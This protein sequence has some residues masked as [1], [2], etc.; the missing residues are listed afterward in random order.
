RANVSPGTSVEV[1]QKQDQRTGRLTLG[2]VGR[3]LTSSGFHP[4]GI[5]VM[6]AGG[7]VGRVQ[8]IAGIDGAEPTPGNAGLN[9]AA[10]YSS[11]SSSSNGSNGVDNRID[12]AIVASSAIGTGQRRRDSPLEGASPAAAASDSTTTEA[13]AAAAA[14]A[15]SSRPVRKFRAERVQGRSW[16]VEGGQVVA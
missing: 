2:T 8:N 9:T 6:L 3:L 13:S 1:V 14:P 7:V 10:G 11:S 12:P 16:S 15:R 5:K 4:R